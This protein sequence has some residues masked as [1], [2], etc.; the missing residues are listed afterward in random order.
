M[1]IFQFMHVEGP[2]PRYSMGPAKNFALGPAISLVSPA[3]CWDTYHIRSHFMDCNRL[4]LPPHAHKWWIG[5][6]CYRLQEYEPI[7]LHCG[8]GMGPA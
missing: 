1:L 5:I 2:T 6:A 4:V 7:K 3:G 8:L